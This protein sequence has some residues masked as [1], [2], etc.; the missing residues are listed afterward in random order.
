MLSL[1]GRVHL[2]LYYMRSEFGSLR[3]R[4]GCTKYTTRTSAPRPRDKERPMPVGGKSCPGS[5]E[6]SVEVDGRWYYPLKKRSLDGLASGFHGAC[7]VLSVDRMG[8]K[9]KANYTLIDY[10]THNRSTRTCAQT[11]VLPWRKIR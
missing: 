6:V 9:A 7:T 10:L 5:S 11:P 1:A 8:M 3:I 4:T 2:G